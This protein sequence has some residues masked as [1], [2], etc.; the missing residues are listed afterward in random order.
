MDE[1]A[2]YVRQNRKLQLF[3]TVADLTL[4][5]AA[6]RLAYA[7]R[8]TLP[9][10]RFFEIPA[11]TQI[12]LYGAAALAWAGAGVW[13][14]TYEL[15]DVARLRD[16][17]VRVL[18]QSAALVLAIVLVE[19]A[20]RYDLSRPFVGMFTAFSFLFVLL[21]RL[22]VRAL[23]ARFGRG[24]RTGTRILL[25]G[26]P[27][28]CRELAAAITADPSV[29]HMVIGHLIPGLTTPSPPEY[30]LDTLPSFLKEN[31]VD[32]IVFALDSASLPDYEE[33]FLLCEEEGVRTRLCL[34]FFPHVHSRVY[35]DRLGPAP[36]LT[37]SGA[38]HDEIRL[39]IK[40]LTDIFVSL[41]ALAASLPFVLLLAAIIRLTSPGPAFFGQTRCGLNGRRFTLWKFRTMVRD[42]EAMKKDLQHLNVKQTAFK[43]PRDPRVTPL[44]RWLRKF[45]IDE[46]PQLWNVLRGDMSLVGPRPAVPEEVEQYRRWQRRRLRMRPGLTCLWTL[47]GRDAVGFEDWMKLDLD[48]ID[49]WSLALDWSI[50]L[51]TIPHVVMG[52]G[53]N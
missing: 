29:P 50:I 28:R 31:V 24:L 7:I 21:F 14:A 23:L 6:F 36:L 39:F 53:A 1:R 2:V 11:P 51:R 16:Q 30:P 49:N 52:K 22:G 9:L 27:P 20:L 45:S 12:V 35:L 25:A 40:R 44:G 48:Y 5:L 3:Y 18:R 19:Y 13:F 32:E 17:V 8:A 47:A 38:P 37:F 43:I 15:L 4:L 10:E 46:W 42:A 26:P 41:A 33:A 34:D